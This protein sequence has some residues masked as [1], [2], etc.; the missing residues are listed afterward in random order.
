MA[1]EGGTMKIYVLE[2]SSPEFSSVDVYELDH[3]TD[4]CLFF[5][6]RSGTRRQ[7]KEAWGFRWYRS[8][9]EVTTAA[10][11]W[12]ENEIA[13]IERRLVV[14]LG[15]KEISIHEIPSDFV[16]PGEVKL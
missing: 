1:G 12:R 11:K 14:L 13:K 2:G 7:L 15:L 5:K 3:E 9:E 8:E 4:K 6:V 16:K 10:K